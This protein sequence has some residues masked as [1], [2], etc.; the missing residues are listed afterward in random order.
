MSEKER[1]RARAREKI[2]VYDK[3]QFSQSKRW[4][5]F[6]YCIF[7]RS[8]VF[9]LVS[10][11]LF[12]FLSL[13]LSLLAAI[14]YCSFRTIDL[15]AYTQTSVFVCN[16]ILYFAKNKTILTTENGAPNWTWIVFLVMHTIA[17]YIHIQ[18]YERNGKISFQRI[19]KYFSIE[20]H[21]VFLLHYLLF[22][23]SLILVTFACAC[24]MLNA[25]SLSLSLANSITINTQSTNKIS[26][27]QSESAKQRDLAHRI[28]VA[29][30]Y[31]YIC[32]CMYV[33]VGAVRMW[34][35]HVAC[36]CVWWEKHV[37]V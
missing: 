15:I 16:A 32:I 27:N 21:R 8:F 2:S 19:T 30:F 24:M 5:Y 10:L 23:C 31:I 20:L 7:V 9:L 1:E 22:P 11:L 18:T 36:V 37:Y 12:S 28:K 3:I 34:R 17:M 6:S 26:S 13:S 25:I 35:F 29:Y 14:S 33:S 4:I